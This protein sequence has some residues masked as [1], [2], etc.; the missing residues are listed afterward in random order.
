MVRIPFGYKSQHTVIKREV[1]NFLDI[2]DVNSIQLFITANVVLW[3][4]KAKTFSVF[5]GQDYTSD[6]TKYS[7]FG[8]I[9]VKN[10][11]DLNVIPQFN[12]EQEE[13]ITNI[14][15]SYHQEKSGLS[16]F[17]VV[18]IVVIMRIYHENENEK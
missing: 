1:L 4:I 13:E 18:N 15:D 7:L 6:H 3:D 14:L 16:V 12:G 9:E 17:E 2:N 10:V 8:P 5:Y 11:G